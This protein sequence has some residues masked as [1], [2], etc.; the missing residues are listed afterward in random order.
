MNLRDYQQTAL[1]KVFISWLEFDR[2][3]LTAATGSGKTIIFSHITKK[4]VGSGGRVLII[5]HVDE[6]IDQAI[7]KLHQ[8]T[9]LFADKEKAG[10]WARRSSSVVVASVQSL[11]G[12][13][14]LRFPADHFSHI[15]VDECH[16]ILAEGYQTILTHF[17]SAKV[18]GV[19][20]TADRGDKK[21]LGAYFQTVADEIQLPTLIKQGHLC[22]ITVKQIPLKIDLT[23]VKRVAGDFSASDLDNTIRP[24]LRSLAGSIVEH[25]SDR[26]TVVY[27]P[28]IKTCR[29]FSEVMND[30]GHPCTFVS[31][32]C[33]DRKE[34]L[35]A[36]HRGEVK[37]IAN[38]MLLTEGWDEPSVSC[39]ANVRP[40]QS[41]SLYV[42]MVGRG[43]RTHPGKENLLILDYLWCTD[44]HSLVK[45]ANLIS[46]SQEEADRMEKIFESQG[47]E[48]MDLL[49]LQNLAI[50]D[51]ENEVREA[52]VRELSLRKAL[53]R[54]KGK[55]G[56]MID[57]I[58]FALSLHDQALIDYEPSMPWESLGPFNWQLEN[59][60]AAGLDPSCVRNRGHAS[61]L[62]ETIKSRR[63]LGLAT[64][65]QVNLMLRYKFPNP[66]AA[67]FAEASAFITQ[68]ANNG[69]RP[70]R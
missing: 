58:E 22:P 70:L 39:I 28:L 60:A 46:K 9:G 17:E 50:E 7:K 3:L 20:A 29:E 8:A 2:V 49:T 19:T 16:H 51:K 31:G 55:K 33:L 21:N 24:M 35:G 52:H 30:L 26:K 44:R 66:H 67:T 15:I 62:C 45:P 11:R 59:I 32:E 64:M 47:F 5:A 43:L 18:L 41:R 53:E 65:K 38:A 23:G 40:T 42:Q 13:R 14:K 36:F 25:A 34:K 48:Q 37:A 10:D 1:D 12:S 68:L 27:L 6:L 4:I 69:W 57:P 63:S 56:R 61:A 54:N